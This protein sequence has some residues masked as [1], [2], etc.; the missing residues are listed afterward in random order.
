VHYWVLFTLLIV[1]VVKYYTAVEMRKLERRLE[2]VKEDLQMAKE[3]L[4]ETQEKYNGI[5]SEEELYLE[6]VTRM[7][8]VIEDIQIRL[9][10]KEDADA[11]EVVVSDGGPPPRA[12]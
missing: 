12:F 7:K 10:T 4:Q 11:E 5:K 1:V 8:E 6:R 3:K 9:T 2:K